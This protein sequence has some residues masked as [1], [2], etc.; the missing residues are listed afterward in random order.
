VGYLPQNFPVAP[1]VGMAVEVRTRAAK[2][3]KGCATV[4]GVGPNLESITNSLVIPLS[5]R[6]VVM[7]MGRKVSISLPEGLELLPGEPVDLVLLEK[8]SP[9]NGRAKD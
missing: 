5:V 7:P 8:S 1:Q 6:P 9:G 4:L 2:R 3:M